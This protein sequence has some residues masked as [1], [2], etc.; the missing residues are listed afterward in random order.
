MWQ[1][2]SF[3]MDCWH[4]KV[5]M[6]YM[7]KKDTCTV[8]VMYTNNARL[9]SQWNNRVLFFNK[10]QGELHDANCHHFMM[11]SFPLS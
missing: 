8:I 10:L 5:L 11:S 2:K 3:V 6:S 7:Y 9:Y 1:L 4:Y